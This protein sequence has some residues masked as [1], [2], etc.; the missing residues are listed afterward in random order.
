M[1]LM[2]RQPG[3]LG[4][5][6]GI[7]RVRRR[8]QSVMPSPIRGIEPADRDELPFGALGRLTERAVLQPKPE[9]SGEIVRWV[10][11]QPLGTERDRIVRECAAENPAWFK[12]WTTLRM[13]D[14]SLR[15]PRDEVAVFVLS[16]FI[17]LP[18]DPPE[19]VLAY[20]RKALRLCPEALEYYIEPFFDVPTD[21]KAKALTA[22]ALR[23]AVSEHWDRLF[24]RAKRWGWIFRLERSLT[25]WLEERR[26]RKELRLQSELYLE[27]LQQR[28]DETR[29][30]VR[31]D[32]P[33]RGRRRVALDH[34]L[35]ARR[36]EREAA[37]SWVDTQLAAAPPE[38]RREVQE[39]EMDL[40]RLAPTV[41][42]RG[43]MTQ[44]EAQQRLDRREFNVAVALGLVT[45]PGQRFRRR[46]PILAI[47]VPDEASLRL[48]VHWDQWMVKVNGREELGTFYHV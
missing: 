32:T 48:V 33:T 4:Q 47:K 12:P 24:A 30:S 15:I 42:A 44:S 45:F 43:P 22:E 8:T 18:G 29:A 7:Y 19:T 31:N 38:V 40:I 14:R 37:S 27:M 17:N 11:L 26:R 28:E 16:D 9:C 1:L 5:R 23:R 39:L 10:S 25:E 46:D 6:S 36:R 34:R 41:R 20:R 3:R 2:E 21:E 35:A 13:F